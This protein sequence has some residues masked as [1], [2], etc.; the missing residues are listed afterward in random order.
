MD[1]TQISGLVSSMNNDAIHWDVEHYGGRKKNEG[2]FYTCCLWGALNA[3]GRCPIGSYR[4][5]HEMQMN[6][7]S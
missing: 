7:L 4:C 5:M 2:R 3:S 1:K 6:D